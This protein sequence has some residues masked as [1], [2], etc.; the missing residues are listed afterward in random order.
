MSEY[1][2]EI[3]NHLKGRGLYAGEIDGLIG[4]VTAKAIVTALKGASPEV[5]NYRVSKNFF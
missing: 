5:Q 3:Q 2:T 1:I 4:P